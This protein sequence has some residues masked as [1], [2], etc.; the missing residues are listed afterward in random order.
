MCERAYMEP[1]ARISAMRNLQPQG[2]SFVFLST[3]MRDRI[4]CVTIIV[5]LF[6]FSTAAQFKIQFSPLCTLNRVHVP[7]QENAYSRAPG[8]FSTCWNVAL[9][10]PQICVRDLYFP[11]LRYIRALIRLSLSVSLLARLRKKRRR[12]ATSNSRDEEKDSALRP[13]A[14]E[15][16]NDRETQKKKT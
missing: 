2:A 14:A 11:G 5:L 13:R 10:P 15:V 1:S 3:F 8:L 6:S 12:N 16:W 9:N 4:R 7:R